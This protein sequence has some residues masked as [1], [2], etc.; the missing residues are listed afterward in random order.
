MSSRCGPATVMPRASSSA[1][2]AASSPASWAA[3]AS[4]AVLAGVRACEVAQGEGLAAVAQLGVRRRRQRTEG[5]DERGSGSPHGATGADHVLGEAP[6]RSRRR[7][8]GA[9]LAQQ[10]VALLEDAPVADEVGGG[11]RVELG[12][13]DVE[14]A[15]PSFGRALDEHEV[16]GPEE[17]HR[18][19][20]EQRTRR[21]LL[22]VDQGGP[23][24]GVARAAIGSP[25]AHVQH[26]RTVGTLDP[27][28]HPACVLP[29]GDQLG[30]G[31]CAG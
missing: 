21:S 2:R 7:L 14:E 4:G 17:H 27:R 19:D 13:D 20:A 26:R 6:Q 12:E 24:R 18:T 28:L 29:P 11:A 31:R 22:A 10:R 30:G 25:D 15:P 1:A 8:A 23:E 3:A 9:D 16:V 5:L